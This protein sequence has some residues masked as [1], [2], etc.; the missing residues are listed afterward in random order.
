MSTLLVTGGA[1]YVG[2]HVAAE[3]IRRRHEV[4][5][6]DDLST[7]HRAAVPE[8]A[9]FVRGSLLDAPAVS[10]LFAQH[11]F[12]GILHFAAL[13]LVGDSLQHPFRYLREN[14]L[15]A[16]QLVEQA[17]RHEVGRFILSST[18][19]LYGEPQR[20]PITEQEP[21]EPA[22]PYGESK[23]FIE[24]TLAW[25]DRIYG[26]R[27]VSLRYFNAAG[28]MPDGSRGEDHDPETHL[29][30][31]ALQAAGGQREALVIYGD[32]YPT[33]DGTCVRDYV[34]VL[35][36]AQ[37]HILALDAPTDRSTAYNLGSGVGHSVLDV[38][39]TV[40]RV[41]GRDFQVTRGDRRPGDP[42]VLVASSASIRRDLGWTPEYATLESIVQTA[43]AWQRSH[44][45][46]YATR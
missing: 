46:G 35:D 31:I 2:C 26:L 1:G 8:G 11:R 3:L 9:L 20:T 43:W 24:R 18:A 39:E 28:A 7:G 12:D 36:L 41:T 25:A 34:H 13:S 45:Q 30:P 15:G 10:G 17:V 38:V 22:S 23:L 42:P 5:V 14:L 6:F 21:L 29:I 32:D 44:P 37:A 16:T 19:N 4:V 40:K 27:S 33:A